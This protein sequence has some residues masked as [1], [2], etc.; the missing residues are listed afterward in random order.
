MTTVKA[1]AFQLSPV[2]Y[3]REGAAEKDSQQVIYNFRPRAHNH[4]HDGVV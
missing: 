1:A 2:L 3:T 4:S